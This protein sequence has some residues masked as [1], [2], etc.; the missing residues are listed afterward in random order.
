MAGEEDITMYVGVLAVVLGLIYFAYIILK[1][2]LSGEEIEMK[3]IVDA[4]REVVEHKDEALNTSENLLEKDIEGLKKTY[5]NHEGTIK[6]EVDE[7]ADLIDDK[8]GEGNE[9]RN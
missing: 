5:K 2:K 7:I 8:E 3:D 6:K 4:S 1:K 9:E